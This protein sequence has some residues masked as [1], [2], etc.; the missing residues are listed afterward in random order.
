M[1][2]APKKYAPR[3]GGF[4]DGKEAGMGAEWEGYILICARFAPYKRRAFSL[5]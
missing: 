5:P 2:A 4:V 1:K 3:G